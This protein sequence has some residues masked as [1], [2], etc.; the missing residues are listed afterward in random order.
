MN[1]VLEEMLLLC[2]CCEEAR[3]GCRACPKRVVTATEMKGKLDAR[4][5]TYLLAFI[6][7]VRVSHFSRFL[8]SL[9]HLCSLRP[10]SFEKQPEHLG[11]SQPTSLQSSPL[12][13][14]RLLAFCA[15]DVPALLNIV[16]AKWEARHSLQPPTLG[17]VT[18]T[19]TFS[20]THCARK[21]FGHSYPHQCASELR[22]PFNSSRSRGQQSPINTNRTFY[23]PEA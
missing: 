9:Q 20:S 10:T 6:S 12:R 13:T 14:T 19:N 18:P 22:T 11:L 3:E 8:S 7:P 2:L 16:A 21:P 5:Q 4:R 1:G 17:I 15:N 23:A